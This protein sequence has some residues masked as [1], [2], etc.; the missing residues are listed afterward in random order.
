MILLL[1]GYVTPMFVTQK[2]SKEYVMDTV[3]LKPEADL[4]RLWQFINGFW[5]VLGAI[6]LLLLLLFAGE[7]VIIGFLLAVWLLMFLL[8]AIY[9]PAFY[10]TLEYVVDND[11]VRLKK[12]VFWRIRTT[13]PYSKITNMDITQGP[14][15]RLYKI[16]H[17]RIQT[18]GASGT[19]GVPAEL[20]MS[21]IRDSEALKDMIMSRIGSPV[22]I[23]TA[24]EPTDDLSL[25]KAILAEL[26][27]IRKAVEK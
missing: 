6:I 20:I 21:G 26:T 14:V 24:K 1:T 18:A 8:I 10:K 11:A 15:E 25:Q 12:G 9:L 19:Q 4:K 27:A 5:F 22:A 17:I 2:T 7:P 3:V 13:V 16:S 23:N